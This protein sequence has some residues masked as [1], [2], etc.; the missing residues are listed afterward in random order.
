MYRAN[1]GPKANYSINMIQSD[2]S[3]FTVPGKTVMQTHKVTKTVKVHKKR[4]KKPA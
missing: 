4:S 1:L 3:K 2:R